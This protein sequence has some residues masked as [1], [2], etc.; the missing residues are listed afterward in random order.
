MKRQIITTKDG[1][2]TLYLPDLYEHYHSNHGALQEAMHVFIKS[3]WDEIEKDHVNIL[4]VGFGSGLNA[5][6]TVNASLKD[7]KKVYYAGLEA[8]PV[9]QEEVD[10]LGYAELEDIE[11][12]KTEFNKMHATKWDVPE[13][14]NELFT[15]EKIQQ[16]MEDFVP[17]KESFDL[18]YFDAFGPRAQPFMWTDE[19]LSK[20]YD[21]LSTNGIFVT[22]CAKGDVRRSLIALGFEV[23]KIP[24]PPG[25]REML[26]ARKR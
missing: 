25:K 10:L 9:T 1:S 11:P 4:E 14:I 15:L 8:F 7:N 22:Y 12:V 19:V 23:E 13:E 18:I 6:I 5:I 2:K 26:R 21:A 24:G 20:M 3:G 16:K 17:K